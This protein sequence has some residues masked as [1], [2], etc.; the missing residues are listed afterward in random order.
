MA[1][2]YDTIVVGTGIGGLTAGLSLARKGRSVLLLEAG[3]QF[4]GMLNPFSRKR[5]HF[6]VGIHYVG[7]AGERQTMRRILDSLGLEDLR[8]REI[9][10]DCI[11]RYIF[12]D[13]EAR[14]VKGF[15]RWGDVLVADF[16]HESE[17]IRRFIELMKACSSLAKIFGRGPRM[18][19]VPDILRHGGDLVRLTHMPFAEILA[20]YF[21]DPRVRNVF[22][23]PGG[24][25]G[26]PPSRAS[27]FFSI[28][29]L[30]HYMGGAYYP[31]GGSGAMRDGYVEGLRKHGAE[32]RRNQ[33]V[34]RIEVLGVE[35]FAVYTAKGE[36]FESRTVISN[37]DAKLTVDMIDGARPNFRTRRKVASLRP[38]LGSFC[39]FLGTDLDLQAAGLDDANIWHYGTN[40]L[41]DAYRSVFEGRTDERPFFFLT[42]PTL[43]DPETVRAPAGHHTLELITFV[44]SELFK[45][46]WDK[47]V[48]RRGG[49]YERIK[50]EI[51]DRLIAGA[52]RHVP[53]LSDHIT[54]RESATPATV[55]HFVRGREGGIYGPEHSPDQS[56]WR[57]LSTKIGIPGLYLTGAS[58]L[59]AGIHT[60]M[61]SGVL[62]AKAVMR[63]EGRPARARLWQ[64]ATRSLGTATRKVSEQLG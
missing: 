28:M 18:R 5:Y 29:L 14:L 15:D 63:S 34:T 24:D 41:E 62:A 8:F 10:P 17:N 26:L 32:L 19:E 46:W 49:D 20:H 53:G 31:V 7:E 21:E 12:G 23:G 59:G 22:A 54:I 40:D 11:D 39:V 25:L 56:L 58:V 60:C 43:K 57:R 50:N 64:R 16:P 52:E 30:N 47:P 2:R 38:S 51:T 42:A 45:P 1:S 61:V 6:D 3:K 36:R 13:Y 33:P 4:G 48:M 44:P 37:V 27:A 55:W 9:N 35:H